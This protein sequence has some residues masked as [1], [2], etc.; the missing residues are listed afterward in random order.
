MWKKIQS[1]QRE[2]YFLQ[3]TGHQVEHKGSAKEK[4]HPLDIYI[5]LNY[6]VRGLNEGL[7]SLKQTKTITF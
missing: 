2:K 3:K 1:Y 6:Q 7:Q 4:Y 5:Q